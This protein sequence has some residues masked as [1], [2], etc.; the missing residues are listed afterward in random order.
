MTRSARL[1][2]TTSALITGYDVEAGYAFARRLRDTPSTPDWRV[3]WDQ[4]PE[5]F[6]VFKGGQR[7]R[8]GGIDPPW[9]ATEEN[10]ASGDRLLGQLLFYGVGCTRIRHQS[11]NTA[12]VPRRTAGIPPY[13]SHRRAV[14][15]GGALY[16]TDYYLYS[17]AIPG[18]PGGLYH[19]SPARHELFELCASEID[20]HVVAALGLPEGAPLPNAILFVAQSFWRSYFKY[21][22]FSYRLGAV[23]TGVAVGRLMRLG[24]VIFSET[25]LQVDFDD[26]AINALLDID[27]RE[28]STYAALWFG[29]NGAGWVSR[30]NDRP[31][32]V[33][34]RKP[35]TACRQRGAEFTPEFWG[36]HQSLLGGGKWPLT[37]GRSEPSTPRPSRPAT[38]LGAWAATL[39]SGPAVPL[40]AVLPIADAELFRTVLRRSSDGVRFN[41]S[42]ITPEDLAAVL[43]DATKAVEYFCAQSCDDG[44]RTPAMLCTVLRVGDISPGTYLYQPLSHA[45]RLIKQRDFG[46][47]LQGAR[48]SDN[49]NVDLAAVVVHLADDMDFRPLLRG[50]REYR[51]QQ[52]IMG[53]AL[54]GVMLASA[55]RGLSAHPVLGFDAAR[56]DRLY[57]LADPNGTLAEICVGCTHVTS[58]YEGSITS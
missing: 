55:A 22:E 26:S 41:G 31:T 39:T 17:R 21:A 7:I 19:Y 15:S 56:I 57:G 2:D 33:A 38:A 18:I 30:Q 27:G 48:R 47:E 4:A 49:I 42:A 36:M 34:S 35:A 3:D 14:A 13:L 58:D 20:A 10:E 43:W 45:L 32:V 52:M 9:C 12:A 40:P 16:P 11:S 54:D 53:A 44:L 24:S 46:I 23:D 6:K 37:L 25:R 51:I 28:E 1:D 5:P 8:L 50:N 29:R